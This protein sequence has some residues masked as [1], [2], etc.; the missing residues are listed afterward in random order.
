M[1]TSDA[2]MDRAVRHAFALRLPWGAG[3]IRAMH[4]TPRTLVPLT[5]ILCL[6]AL[7]ACNCDP[8]EPPPAG[9]VCGTG[10]IDGA[11]WALDPDGTRALLVVH[12]KDGAGCGIFH[13]HVVSAKVARIEYDLTAATP[14]D[15]SVKVTL[16]AAGLEPD[17][18]E[19]RA[20]LLPEGENEPL[21]DGDRKS[22]RGSVAEEVLAAE[23]P[24]LVF[25]FT[26]LSSA[27]GTGTARMKAELAGA[28]DEENVEYTVERSGDRIS[29]SGAAQLNGAPFG[30]P[31]NSLGFCVE[32]V[33]DI[34]FDLALVPTQAPVECIGA[35]PPPPWE[36]RF[37]D[38]TAC[39]DDVGYNDV[40]AV[41][42]RSCGGCHGA[43]V[44][45]GATIPL[46]SWEDW[47]TDSIR[48]QGQPL[49]ETAHDYVHLSPTEGL[50]MPPVDQQGEAM[51]TPLTA[52]DIAL[53]DAWVAGGARRER[54]NGDPGLTTFPDIDVEAKDCDD[55]LHYDAPDA[56]GN[57]ARTFF[58]SYCA[59][60]HLDAFESYPQVPQIS[61][62]GDD[63]RPIPSD[64]GY[65]ELDVAAAERGVF[66]PWYLGAGGAP[67]SF[68][69]TSVLRVEDHTM[70]PNMADF[71]LDQD[72]SFAQF[73]A[74]VAAGAAPRACATAP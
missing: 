54:C 68:W 25:T 32:P 49:Y 52:D 14:G 34:V 13:S 4:R 5:A 64:T 62:L 74:W 53:F 45:L 39:A 66:H 2:R 71:G 12:R 11:P 48:N 7:S 47:R 72:P 27:D 31:R 17:D 43:E 50:S 6:A 36:P 65:A 42:V 63:G 58:E 29:V 73:K 22:I 21:S 16:L 56:E 51:A 15:G 57:T 69:E 26:G 35:P 23:H 30:I 18:P 60:C 38:D 33:M 28:T 8:V 9:D 37:F 1:A 24:E 19:L 55:D 44:R 59:Y 41:A 61:A 3:I 10:T 40:R 20:E 46:V 67:L 70:P